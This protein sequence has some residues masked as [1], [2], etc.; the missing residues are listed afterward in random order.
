MRS[1]KSRYAAQLAQHFGAENVTYVAML[2]AG[3]VDM[4]WRL[5]GHRAH[6]PTSWQ[7]LERHIRPSDA[8][9]KAKH[10]VV[11]IDSLTSWVANILLEHEASGAAAARDAVTRETDHFLETLEHSPH[12]VIMATNEVGA[13][14]LPSNHLG[15]WT[16]EA[17]GQT[18]Q[19]VASM[20]DTVAQVIVGLP[21]LLKGR[22]PEVAP[23][24]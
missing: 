6:H 24:P 2:A 20:C 22:L 9:T 7:T 4:L 19:R 18:N 1:G 21:Q 17:L 5:D 12:T 15:M 8:L 14:V 10:D 16:R 11:I 13:G 23:L 3:D